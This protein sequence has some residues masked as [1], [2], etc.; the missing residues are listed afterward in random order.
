MELN[1]IKI[2][3]E[4]YKNKS[5]SKT[6]EKLNYSQSNISARLKKLEKEFDA[7]FFRRTKY[8]LELLPAAEQ[9]MRYALQINQISDDLYNEFCIDNKETNIA[10][11]QLLSRLYFPLLYQSKVSINLYTSSNKKLS[12]GF[13][14]NIFDIIIT[15]TRMNAKKVAI[16]YDKTELLLWTQS[17]KFVNS[18]DEKPSI[19][20]S[21]DKSCP[22][23]KAS[24]HTLT[25]HKLDLPIIEVDTIDIMLTLVHSIN[26]LVL[27]PQKIVSAEK[28][29]VE[30]SKLR[31][32]PL[33]VFIYCYRK[34]N[35]ELVES[36]FLSNASHHACK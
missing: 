22:L 25:Q 30:F 17:K 9:F 29:L 6:A 13:D 23:R 31:A 32:I 11:T 4:L 5:I 26:S 10:S 27:L 28:D 24:L 12:R 15:H 2:F 3:I 1:D 35:S 7:I 34:E 14:N 33:K 8:G 18:N 36:L 16:C 21:R 20:V 19:I